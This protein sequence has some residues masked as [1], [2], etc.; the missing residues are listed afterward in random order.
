MEDFRQFFNALH[1]FLMSE[2]E[3]LLLLFTN[4]NFFTFVNAYM[5]NLSMVQYDFTNYEDPPVIEN[6]DWLATFNNRHVHNSIVHFYS[7]PI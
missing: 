4:V 1:A 5:L 3:E 7:L 6:A 2:H